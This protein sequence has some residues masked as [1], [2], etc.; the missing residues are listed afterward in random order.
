MGS[1]RE[2][3]AAPIPEI[4]Y[5]ST[6]GVTYYRKRFFG[7]G[8]FAK[9][10][11]L[12]KGSTDEIYA[13]KIVSKSTLKKGNQREKMAQEIEI[14]RSLSHYHVVQFHGYFEDPNNVYV[15]LELCRKRSMME[16]HKRRKALTEPEVRFFMKQ[17]LEGV[18]YLHNLNIIHRDLKLGNLFLNDDLILKI[19]DFGLAAKIEYSGQRKKTVCGTPNYIAPEILNKKGHSF[20]VDVWSIG[21]IMFTLL[22]GKPPFE[23]SS[24]RET[25][26]KIRRCEYTIPPSV[27]EPAAQMVHQMLTP[28][29]SLRPTVKQL[30]KSNFMI[31]GYC[32]Q[33]LPPSIL[34]TEPR[35]N[36]V[37]SRNIGRKPFTGLENIRPTSVGV[38]P[39][40]P[41]QSYA[42]GSSGPPVPSVTSQQCHE[43]L[44]QL[45]DQLRTL[46]ESKP[47]VLPVEQ[48]EET[49]DPNACPF[50]W[51]SKWVDYSDK[52][53]F[54]YQLCDEGVGVVFND[55]TKLLL[56]PNHRNI[57]YI[58]RD[59]SEQY[60][61]HNKTP[62]ELDKKL[63]LLSY[64]R[65]YMTEHLMK[66]GDTIR[67]QEADNLSRA[68]YLHMWQRSSSGVMLQLTN[69]TFQIN[70]STDHSKIIMCPL[71]QA[72]TYIDADKN[73]RTYRFNT[74]S[75]CGAVPGLLENLEYAYRKISAILQVQK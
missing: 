17:L 11:E 5:D 71:M 68:P 57:H 2:E 75:S 49:S 29:P 63:K 7:K 10:Y 66:A 64:F 27:S 6:N 60:Y 19:G 42:A 3:I 9:C 26:A 50:V 55:N 65:R 70:F 1:K 22:V 41:R 58:E 32:P 16:L 59:G 45:H 53:G 4:I 38:S 15:L 40:K 20:E 52:Y 8:G 12:Q 51:I 39:K 23:T 31:N 14:H 43:Y 28:E 72:V 13:G 24:L 33:M 69:G 67:T 62:A 44:E 21:C 36:E 48:S 54:G 37:V 30:L 35:F 46:L 61:V 56:L 74:I 34:T 18:L 47:R 73:F 25:Y